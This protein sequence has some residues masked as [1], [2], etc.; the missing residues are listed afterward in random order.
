M[1]FCLPFYVSIYC[2]EPDTTQPSA[3]WCLFGSQ[4]PVNQERFNKKKKNGAGNQIYLIK[5]RFG[6]RTR[7]S[8]DQ[9]PL[10]MSWNLGM[11]RIGRNLKV[12]L[13]PTHLPWASSTILGW[14]KPHPTSSWTFPGMGKPQ[15]L[16]PNCARDSPSSEGRI[17]SQYSIKTCLLSGG[18]W[19]HSFLHFQI[20]KF[21]TTSSNWGL[22]FPIDFPAK[23]LNQEEM[24]D[25][26]QNSHY[27]SW[28]VQLIFCC[29]KH[30]S[31]W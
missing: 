29:P 16:W 24:T 20:S 22:I 17:L 30:Q 4:A 11:V 10:G 2:W 23:Q 15:L 25:I 31:I 26:N 12:H 13:I 9:L 8:S 18:P 19:S 21:L 14:S 7:C 1:G 6:F 27:L 5:F 28:F 3:R